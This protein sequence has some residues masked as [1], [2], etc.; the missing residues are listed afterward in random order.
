[1]SVRR[2]AGVIAGAFLAVALVV[3][4]ANAGEGDDATTVTFQ[5]PVRIPG[6][7]LAPGTYYF[8]CI[9]DG[10]DADTNLI[11][12]Y[13]GDR[14]RFIGIVETLPVER[15]YASDRT[16]LT[17]AE[18]TKGHPPALVDWFYPGSLEGRQFLYSP[19]RESRIEQ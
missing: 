3:P 14:T 17:L 11:L 12:V 9:D 7:V 13:N 5:Q 18:G 15:Q 1:M 2:L 10:Q 16:V 6:H 4:I 19:R 8:T